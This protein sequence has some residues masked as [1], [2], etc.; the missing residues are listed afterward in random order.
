[1][2]AAPKPDAPPAVLPPQFE[3][4]WNSLLEHVPEYIYVINPDGTLLYANR[5]LPAETRERVIGT[6]L[7]DWLPPPVANA[8]RRGVAEVVRTRV[9]GLVEMPTSPQLGE[10]WFARRIAPVLEDN[11]VVALVVI[12]TDV[13]D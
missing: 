13:T 6:S 5:V 2:R 9:A 3:H 12:A 10:R 8:M 1:M 4:W 7:Y 11:A